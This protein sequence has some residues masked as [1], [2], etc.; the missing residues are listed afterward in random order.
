MRI[1]VFLILSTLFNT[2]FADSL[3]LPMR[4]RAV[5]IDQI[6]E[7]NRVDCQVL[8][9]IV[10]LLRKNYGD[11]INYFYYFSLNVLRSLIFS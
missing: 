9:E 2:L 3:I 8:Y 1:T 6:I 4:E 11:W 7:Y 5:A 10:E